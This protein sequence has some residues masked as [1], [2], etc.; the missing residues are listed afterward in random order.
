MTFYFYQLKVFHT[1][2]EC[3]RG[4]AANQFDLTAPILPGFERSRVKGD[5]LFSELSIIRPKSRLSGD[6][7][8]SDSVHSGSTGNG[9]A[10]IP[11]ESL[12]E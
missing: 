11:E 4:V 12:N 6:S 9:R 3:F 5:V 7:L 2:Q 1:L 10:R 8:G